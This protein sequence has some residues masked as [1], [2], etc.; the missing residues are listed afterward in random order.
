MRVGCNAFDVKN[1]ISTPLSFWLSSDIWA[2][3]DLHDLKICP[4]YSNEI[5][6]TGCM[7][8]MFGVHK[9]K[10]P[11]RFQLMKQ[12]HPKHWSYCINKLGL[13]MVL[14]YINVPYN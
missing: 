6:N 14:D 12:T 5:T 8:C 1:P 2:Y 9:E 3:I 7:F 4:I 13:G 11:N 10:E